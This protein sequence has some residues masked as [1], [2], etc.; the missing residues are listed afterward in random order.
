[1]PVSLPEEWAIACSSCLSP[2]LLPAAEPLPA[3]A[4]LLLSERPSV[5]SCSE[6]SRG[7]CGDGNS[8][9]EAESGSGAA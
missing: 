4:A 6:Q 9:S 3:A 5:Q 2:A 1:M 8:A 7:V